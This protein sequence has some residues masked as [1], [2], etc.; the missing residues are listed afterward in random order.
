V[1]GTWQMAYGFGV[2][3]PNDPSQPYQPADQPGQPRPS[4]AQPEPDQP[5]YQQPGYSGY[6]GYQ[7]Q[8][9]YPGYQQPGYQQPGYQQPGYQP[10]YSQWPSSEQWPDSSRGPVRRPGVLIAAGVL[11][12]LIALF[13][14]LLGVLMAVAGQ[15]PG[16]NE[17]MR[18]QGVIITS[19][20]LLASG[21][22]VIAFG[23]AIGLLTIPVFRGALWARIAIIAV[24][25]LPTFIFARTLI[26]P[27]F[28]I[29]AAV[30][31]FLPA[32]NNYALDRRRTPGR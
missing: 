10:G 26:F 16:F 3:S 5:G 27:L 6:P 31:Q 21:L 14:L 25:L 29:A 22:V 32:A 23:L 8:P 7:Q 12:L 2:S 20:Q 30:L 1:H 17:A 18:E 15:L 4:A 11:W 13:L 24:A 19:E 9:G 28:V